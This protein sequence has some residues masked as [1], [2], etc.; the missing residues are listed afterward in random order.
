M[1]QKLGVEDLELMLNGNRVSERDD[2]GPCKSIPVTQKE[3]ESEHVCDWCG[4]QAGFNC[5]LH[6]SFPVVETRQCGKS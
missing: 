4:L 1:C 5:I 2:P 6:F 3:C